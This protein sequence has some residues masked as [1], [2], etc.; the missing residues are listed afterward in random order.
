MNTKWFVLIVKSRNEIK[1]SEK[2]KDLNYEVYCPLIK[3]LR[4]WSDRKKTVEVPLFKSYVFVRLTDKE[5]QSVF[6]IPGVSRYLFWLG[7]P[8]TVRDEEMGELQKWLSDESIE[9]VT[10]S[11]IVPGDELTV[12]QGVLKDR[13][14]VVQEVG[15]KRVKVII[16]GLGVVISLRLKELV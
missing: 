5:R 16:Q 1:V 12:K 9:E 10:L 6:T 14:V 13:H 8:A 2:L 4:V 15:N 3:E 7:Q 11:K